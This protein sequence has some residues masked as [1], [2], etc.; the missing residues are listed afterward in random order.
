ML[1]VALL[2]LVLAGG[3]IGALGVFLSR[4]GR[5]E[6]R[7][8]VDVRHTGGF[9]VGRRESL[10]LLAHP[11]GRPVTL[12]GNITPA[13]LTALSGIWTGTLLYT[14]GSRR[15]LALWDDAGTLIYKGRGYDAA[16]DPAVAG[17]TSATAA[18]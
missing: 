5:R 13:M 6:L 18:S 15:A 3:T 1:W 14:P 9:R 2:M 11:N 10:V 4:L 12:P 17:P 8:G 7:A 16:A